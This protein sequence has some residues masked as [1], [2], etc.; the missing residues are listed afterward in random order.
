MNKETIKLYGVE[1][2]FQTLANEAKAYARPMD[3]EYQDG[4]HKELS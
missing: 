3:E 2:V 4:T 1:G